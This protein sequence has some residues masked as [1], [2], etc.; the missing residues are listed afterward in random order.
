MRIGI[1]AAMPREIA[2]LVRSWRH[3]VL[4]A[5]PAAEV[6]VFE[7]ERALAACAGMGAEQVTHAAE[8]VVQR[9][10]SMLISVGYAGALSAGASCGTVCVPSVIID[11]ATGERFATGIGS[12][13]L[14]SVAFVAGA[15]S[16][17]EL[18][19]RFGGDLVDMEAAAVARHAERRGL[20][21][22]AVKAISDTREARLPDLSRFQQGGKF[23]TGA[24]MRHTALRP[25]LWPA[26]ARLGRDSARAVQKLNAELEEWIAAGGPPARLATDSIGTKS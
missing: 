11:A 26:V 24:F 18:A 1:V 13:V 21:F 22:Y 17:K 3:S 6:L 10:A 2:P 16:K 19:T 12:G 20:P 8:A 25:W 15:S 23:R 4:M 5:A 7:S 14:V 9:G